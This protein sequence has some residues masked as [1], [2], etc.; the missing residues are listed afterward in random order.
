MQIILV[1]L[2]VLLLSSDGVHVH[3]LNSLMVARI[4]SRSGSLRYVRLYRVVREGDDG[5]VCMCVYIYIYTHNYTYTYTYT[6][7]YIYIYIYTHTY[8][9]MCI[10]IYIRRVR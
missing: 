3:A 1:L 4:A 7:T 5:T 10:Y 6:Y 9:Y 8:M 2:L